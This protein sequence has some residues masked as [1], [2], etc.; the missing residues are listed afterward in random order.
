MVASNNNNKPAK[1]KDETK[2]TGVFS[3]VVYISH[4]GQEFMTYRAAFS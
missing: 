4:N 3:R 2:V 1:Q